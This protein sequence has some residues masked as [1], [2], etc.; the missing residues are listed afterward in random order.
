MREVRRV[1]EFVWEK[2]GPPS[3]DADPLDYRLSNEGVEIAPAIREEIR[4]EMEAFAVVSRVRIRRSKLWKSE[5]L[6]HEGVNVTFEC[7]GATSGLGSGPAGALTDLLRDHSLG[8]GQG[9]GVVLGETPSNVP[10]TIAYTRET[11]PA[12]RR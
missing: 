9:F 11:P 8:L 5:E 10:G 1:G 3:E 2:T 4:K 7:D 12:S 6:L